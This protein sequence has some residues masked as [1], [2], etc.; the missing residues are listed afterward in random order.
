MGREFAAASTATTD[1][2][3]ENCQTGL[4]YFVLEVKNEHLE[5]QED[6]HVLAEVIRMVNSRAC[7]Q[8]PSL[9][10]I[11]GHKHKIVSS[12]SS[13]VVNH[14]RATKNKP[15]ATASTPTGCSTKHQVPPSTSGTQH[16]ER[17]Q[18]NVDCSDE[19]SR[20]IHSLMDREFR[21]TLPG[22]CTAGAYSAGGALFENNKTL[23]RFFIRL[24]A[25]RQTA[26]KNDRGCH[27]SATLRIMNGC[28]W[29]QRAAPFKG[30]FDNESFLVPHA[31]G[32]PM[33]A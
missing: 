16:R 25:K 23:Q 6:T 32:Y 7:R 11:K 8:T 18:Q 12:F 9:S 1:R 5:R 29:A 14:R 27:Q 3:E 28:Q 2:R 10:V 31:T 19:V 20:K 15:T 26:Q 24:Y 21:P 4:V 13:F 30:Y 33:P 17:M 22:S